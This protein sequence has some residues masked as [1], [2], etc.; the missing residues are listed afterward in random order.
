MSSTLLLAVR[1]DGE[2][3]PYANYKNAWHGAM[4][5]WVKFAERYNTPFLMGSENVAFWKLA[6][7]PKVPFFDRVTLATTYDRVV[8]YSGDFKRLV[9]ALRQSSIWLPEHCHIRKQADDIEKIIELNSKCSEPELCIVGV[10]WNQTS[11][12][13][14]WETGETRTAYE[15][16]ENG[17]RE[18]YLQEVPYN[19]YSMNKHHNL[20]EEVK[21][22]L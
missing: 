17:R 14:T 13:D 21:E 4:L 22:V 12:V 16:D 19:I 18:E 8:V 9:E 20:F 10:A 3:A 7:D 6:D 11:V 1:G 5:I 15:T 2:L